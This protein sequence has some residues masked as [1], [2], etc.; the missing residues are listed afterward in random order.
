M[1]RNWLPDRSKNSWTACS[2]AL[3]LLVCI[4]LQT[5]IGC[6]MSAPMQVL[7]PSRIDVPAT[8]RIAIA[9]IAARESLA[10]ELERAIRAQSPHLRGEIQLLTAHDLMEAS[11]VRLASTAPADR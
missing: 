5:V 8:S 4:Y 9:P 6:V 11:P 1:Q 3:S 10:T 7:H 2:R